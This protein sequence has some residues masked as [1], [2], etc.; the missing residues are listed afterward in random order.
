M[1]KNQCLQV[2]Q[3]GVAGFNYRFLSVYLCNF[4]IFFNVII[5]E[6]L[7]IYVPTIDRPPFEPCSRDSIAIS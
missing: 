2:L 5:S 3:H 6:S 4:G 1:E 7:N